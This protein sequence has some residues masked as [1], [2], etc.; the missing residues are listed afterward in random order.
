ML[1]LTFNKQEK[2]KSRKLTKQLFAEG[3]SFLVF[4]IKVVYLPITEAVNFPIKIGVS[5]SSKTFKNAVDRNRIKRVLKEQYR[6]NKLPL[7]QHIIATKQQIA[8]FFI[9][10]DKTLPQKGLVEK[11][12]PIIIN[13]LIQ[14]INETI[15]TTA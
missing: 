5:A 14:T 13:K 12:M 11:K 8:V 4:P 1:T 15:V 3:K 9:F 7:H 6:L 10:I 2:L